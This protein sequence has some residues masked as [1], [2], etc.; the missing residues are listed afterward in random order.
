MLPL[1]TPPSIAKVAKHFGPTAFKKGPRTPKL[2][3]ICPEDCFSGLQSG[4]LET[5]K[6]VSKFERNDQ[7]RTNFGNFP[8]VRVPQKECG[9]RSSITFF[10]FRD[11]FVSLFGHFFLTLLSLF[12]S[13]FCQTPFARTPFCGR[14][15]DWN[16]EKLSSGYFWTNLAF[17]AF[18]N[19]VRGRRVRKAKGRCA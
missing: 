5:V 3:E 2:S 6:S 9:K 17:G 19:A 11:A 14:V 4:G 15:T 8:G 16:P 1:K 18:F 12:S 7:F 13:L 10:H